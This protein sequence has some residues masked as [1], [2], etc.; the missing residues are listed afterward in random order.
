MVPLSR[1]NITK[2][3]VFPGTVTYVTVPGKICDRAWENRLLSDFEILVPRRSAID[4]AWENRPLCYNF[5]LR[6]NGTTLKRAITLCNGEVRIAIVSQKKTHCSFPCKNNSDVTVMT[7]EVS[8]Q[9]NSPINIV[10]QTNLPRSPVHPPRTPI[11]SRRRR[12]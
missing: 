5:R 9:S 3:S 2:W 11:L 8:Q 1:K 6:D 12:R 10:S 4:H 7:L